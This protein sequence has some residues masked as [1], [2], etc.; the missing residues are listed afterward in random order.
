[1]AGRTH[2]QHAVPVTFGYKCAVYLSGF[3]RHLQRL[4]EL[5]S[6][7]LTVQFGGAAGTLASLGPEGMGVRVRKQLAAELGLR[8]PLITWHVARD[9]VAEVTNFLALIG[10]SLRKVALDIILMSSNEVSEVS[11]PFL[12][13]RGA[14]ST[15]PQKRNPISSEVILASSKLLRANAGLGMDAM[16]SDFE[17]ASGPWHLEWVCIPDSFVVCCGALHQAHFALSGIV[18]NTEAMVTNLNSSQGLIVAEAVMMGLAPKIGRRQAH[19]VVYRACTI[20]IETKT[21][22]FN[23]LIEDREVKGKLDEETLRELCDPLKYLG[24]CQIMVDTVIDNLP[25]MRQLESGTVWDRQ[26][27]RHDGPQINVVRSNY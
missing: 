12:P 26:S 25:E 4:N 7:C 10:G 19:D 20:S 18:V 9:N 27:H 11:E 14:S 16:V 5:E 21:S 6:R 15:M 22:L 23:V 24:C 2:L 8:D 3:Y 1:M 17:R 13:H